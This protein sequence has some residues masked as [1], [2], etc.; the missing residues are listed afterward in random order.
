MGM[1]YGANYADIIDESLLRELCSIEFK[2]LE[3]ALEKHDLNMEGYARE[4]V[5]NGGLDE[6]ECKDIEDA[7]Q[8]LRE[9]FEIVTEG[10]TLALDFHDSEE[11][12]DR[13]DDVN[14]YYWS[15][16]G[17]YEMTHAGKLMQGK[18]ERKFFVTFG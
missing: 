8:R 13:Y 2:A 15:V 6:N 3:E 7:Y 4:I 12:G 16:Y 1:G 17:V 18:I 10:L 11:C 9:V 5:W 14:G